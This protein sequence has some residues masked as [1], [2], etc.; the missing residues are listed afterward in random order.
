M[1]YRIPLDRDGLLTKIIYNKDKD[2]LSCEEHGDMNVVA[3]VELK[4]KK[5]Y[6]YRCIFCNVGAGYDKDPLTNPSREQLLKLE[7]A[8]KYLNS[9]SPPEPL[10]FIIEDLK[11]QA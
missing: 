7:N 9:D 10:I 5:V 11:K 6:W 1:L 8:E 2:T 4:G 3:I